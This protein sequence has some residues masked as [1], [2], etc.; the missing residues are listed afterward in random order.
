MSEEI[1]S[2]YTVKSEDEPIKVKG[3]RK[4]YM[5]EYYA[6]N[7]IEIIKKICEKEQCPYCNRSVA[8][9]QV[10]KHQNTQYCKTRRELKQRILKELNE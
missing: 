7:K 9:Q 3:D 4:T 1:L 8:H 2:E 6:K 5:K 10:I